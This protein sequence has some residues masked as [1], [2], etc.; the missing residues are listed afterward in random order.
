[1]KKN[2][3]ISNYENYY[4]RKKNNN[5][6]PSELLIKIFLGTTTPIYSKHKLKNKKILDLSF[7]DGRNLVFFKKLG[8][9]VYGTEI[10][11]KIVKI[12]TSKQKLKDR[13]RVGTASDI[14]F[15][16][17]FFDYV[18]AYHSAYYLK[19]G[20]EI[21]KNLNEIFRIMKKKSYF[22]GTI[23]LK[24]NYYFKG[25]KYLKKNQFKII[26]DPLKIRNNSVLACVKNK[27]E[28]YKMLNKNF[29]KI[30]IGKF[31]M[32]FFGFK[33]NFLFFTVEK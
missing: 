6:F 7:G 18:V 11:S 31:E 22:F 14:P 13:F 33:E 30:R 10:S 28:L 3:I 4:K 23:P 20:D 19:E 25:A 15:Q 9:K 24:S 16:N 27:K 29:K 32:D 17:S 1:M 12:I 21:E 26:N 2:K 8:L 5:L